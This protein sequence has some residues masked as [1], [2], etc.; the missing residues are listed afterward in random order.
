MSGLRT[1]HSGS[2]ADGQA[3]QRL[4]K[5]L[6]IV[7]LIA[8][9]ALGVGIISFTQTNQS[10]DIGWRAYQDQKYGFSFAYPSS[11]LW[12]D[13]TAD[14]RTAFQAEPQSKLHNVTKYLVFLKDPQIPDQRIVVVVERPVFTPLSP[15]QLKRGFELGLAQTTT[16]YNIYRSTVVS[17][18]GVNSLRVSY[19]SPDIIQGMVTKL[20]AQLIPDGEYLIS[21]YVALR[22]DPTTEQTANRILDS[23]R[24]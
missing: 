11:Y 19:S 10:Q 13:H 1:Q 18:S 7:G 3:V 2:T 14:F 5:R 16:T 9:L 21:V 6:L 23:F 4:P 8:S 20:E 24:L 15:E 17:I 22:D 12:E